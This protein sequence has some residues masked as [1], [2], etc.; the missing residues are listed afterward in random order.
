MMKK[1]ILRKALEFATKKHWGQTYGDHEFIMHPIE[2][3]RLLEGLGQ[4]EEVIAAGYLHDTLEDTDTTYEELV[5]RFGYRVA[6]RVFEVT[7]TGYNTFPNLFTLEGVLIL[8]ASRICNLSHMEDWEDRD[9][10][11]YIAKSRFWKQ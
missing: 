10:N 3:A 11:L 7:K 8:M 2:V 6:N 1:S 4:S 9:K 5:K